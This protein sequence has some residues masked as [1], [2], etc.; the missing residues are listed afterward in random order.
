MSHDRGCSCGKEPYEYDNC[1]DPNC[2]KK[3]N[4]MEDTDWRPSRCPCAVSGVKR[5]EHLF[6]KPPMSWLSKPGEEYETW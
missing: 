3:D 5:R 6:V 1:V 2:F 4:Q